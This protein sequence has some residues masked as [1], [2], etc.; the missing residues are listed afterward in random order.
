MAVDNPGA[1][2][3]LDSGAKRAFSAEEKKKMVAVLTPEQK[4]KLTEMVTG[5]GDSKEKSKKDKN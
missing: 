5:E 2:K 4:K 3:I 1:G